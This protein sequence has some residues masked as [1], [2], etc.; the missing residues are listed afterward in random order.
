MPIKRAAMK[1][2]RSDKKK[3]DTNLATKSEIKTLKKNIVKKIVKNETTDIQLSLKDFC[4]SVDK[5]ANKGILHKKN[6]ARKISR[7]SK[8]IS[9]ITKS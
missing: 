5:A 8:K 6:A 4:S 9:F 3:H 1:S 2:L 7:I